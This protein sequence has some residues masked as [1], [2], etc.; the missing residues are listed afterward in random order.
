M[1]VTANPAKMGAPAKIISITTH[2]TVRTATQESLVRIMLIG[3][4]QSHV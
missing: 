2:V 1:N 3:A 4:V